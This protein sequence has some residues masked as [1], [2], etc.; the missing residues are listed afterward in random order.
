MIIKDELTRIAEAKRLSLKNAEKDYLLELALFAIFSE[1]GDSLAF[2]GGT[3]LYKFY[4]L[5]RFSED[6]DFTIN[7]RR[8]DIRNIVEKALRRLSSIGI[9]GKQEIESYRNETNARLLFKGPL[10][11]GSKESLAFV[12]INCSMRERPLAIKKEFFVPS[13]REIPS[14]DVFVMGAEE[15]L[16]EKVRAIFM[17]NKAR[18]AYDLWFLLKRGTA[19]NMK[20]ISKKLKPPKIAFS[21]T[22]FIEKL[23][24]K[25]GFF[26]SDMSGLI[27]GELPDFRKIKAEI[28]ESFNI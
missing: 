22:V 11:N 12:A 17:R 20:I 6:L 14:F 19:P 15:I 23:E 26:K 28:L 24:E 2:K 9:E 10:Y 13:Y 4:N 27:I 5:N 8:I 7:K 21:K 1:T 3:A 25:E 16:A 18:D